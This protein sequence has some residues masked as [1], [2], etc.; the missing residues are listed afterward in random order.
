MCAAIVSLN[1][2]MRAPVNL[3]MLVV[4][5]LLL[6]GADAQDPSAER[7]RIELQSEVELLNKPAEVFLERVCLSISI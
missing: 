1:V 4:Q 6:P 2:D 3:C 7:T 5:G